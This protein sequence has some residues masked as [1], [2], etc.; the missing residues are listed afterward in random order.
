MALGDV[1]REGVL[2]AIRECDDKGRDAFLED[3]H[4]GRARAYD[5]VHEGRSYDSKAIAG[6]A[7]L[8]STGVLLSAGEFTG[9]AK[10]VARRLTALGFTIEYRDRAKAEDPGAHAP[11]TRDGLLT[12]LRQLR[13][14]GDE[15]PYEQ[16]LTLL[17]A[18]TRITAG[19]PRL[20]QWGE[21]RHD[22]GELL[23]RLGVP[24]PAAPKYPSSR[25]LTSGVWEVDGFG[26]PDSKHKPP[27]DRLDA[28]NPAAGFTAE[29]ER[30]LQDALI[31]LEAV[32]VLCTMYLHSVD[33][34]E[35]LSCLG[36]NGYETAGG[37][38]PES[39]GAAGGKQA[40]GP[41]E[42]Q[43]TTV[44]RPARDSKLAEKVKRL[45]CDECQICGLRLRTRNGYYSEAAHIRGLGRPHNG[46]DNLANLLCLCPN[47][48][49]QFDTLA[50][51]IDADGTI[52]TTYDSAPLGALHQ[53]D[54][55]RIDGSHLEYHRILC[56]WNVASA[57][58]Q[59][60]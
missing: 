14:D 57:A 10:S 17:W 55:H 33:R 42:R 6:V 24:Q 37:V 47:H 45:H 54:E 32:S 38:V 29:A 27:A 46:P 11:L 2:A 40:A 7:H 4:F 26:V 1:T 41:V 13:I 16:P 20:A 28:I 3:H 44:L 58:I 18:V 34:H 22:V 5:L 39:P 9:G 30:L 52:R 50:I 60:R 56:H 12:R 59:H 8:H 19:K 35:L 21:F 31:R 51:Y 48:H 43:A 25:L 36:L 15:P 49:V 53:H 23:D